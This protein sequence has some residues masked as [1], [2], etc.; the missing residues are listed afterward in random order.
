MILKNINLGLEKNFHG[1]IIY[2]LDNKNNY[3]VYR[4]FL[5]KNPKIYNQTGEDISKEFGID[6]NKGSEF[7]KE[8][9]KIEEDMLCSTAV[10]EQ[11]ES[12]LNKDQQ[13]IVIQKLTNLISAGNDNISFKKIIEKLNKKQLEEVGTSKTL[14]RPINIV[15]EKL[16]KLNQQKNEIELVKDKK[17]EIENQIKIIEKKQKELEEKI[18]IIK[19]IKENKENEKIDNEIILLNNKTIEETIK[20]INELKNKKNIKKIKY[21]KINYILLI[22]FFII[23]ILFTLF[24]PIIILNYILYGIFIIYFLF[25]GINTFSNIKKNKKI[26]LEKNQLENQIFILEE[27][28]NNKEKEIQELKNKLKYK[29]EN[30]I[31]NLQLEFKNENIKELNLPLEEI[32]KYLE[33]IETEYRN[34]ILQLQQL[35]LEKENI[36]QLINKQANIYEQITQLQNEKNNL[37]MLGNAIQIAK[38]TLEEAYNIMKTNVTPEFIQKL[39]QIVKKITKDEYNNIKFNDSE[40][41]TVENKN[42]QYIP[43]YMLSI[44]TIDQIY[45]ALRLS[46]LQQLTTEKIPIILDEIFAYYDNGRLKNILQYLYEEYNDYQIILLTCSN[47]EKEVLDNLKIPYSL[48]ELV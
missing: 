6:K 2:E 5:K 31:N 16:N 18:K 25:L 10:I 33:E 8:Q 45:F 39:N 46:V 41:I 30:N 40:G 35:N 24:N 12:E 42:G 3:E 22:I 1:K 4:D 37:N 47:R 44:G 9:T 28:K 19:I 43:I 13:N 20:K 32:K 27:N 23:N 36:N 48:T 14:E 38:N 21:K 11:G 29:I 15:T 26:K 7:F 34:T 17:Y